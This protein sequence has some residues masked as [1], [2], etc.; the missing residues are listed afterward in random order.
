[1][2]RYGDLEAA[3]DFVA[4]GKDVNMQDAEKRTPLHYSAAHDHAHIM[5]FLLAE[6]ANVELTDTKDNTPLHYAAGYGRVDIVEI[7]LDAGANIAALNGTGKTPAA[8]ARCVCNTGSVFL[9]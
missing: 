8:L 6:G 2:F 1:M 9:D 3:E 7:L 5:R 4:V